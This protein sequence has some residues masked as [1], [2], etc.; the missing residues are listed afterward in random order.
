MQAALLQRT[1][2]TKLREIIVANQDKKHNIVVLGDLNVL[3]SAE[4]TSSVRPLPTAIEDFQDWQ[5]R[6]GLSNAL[7]HG[8]TGASIEK[9]YF[10]RSRTSRHGAELSLIDHIL[11]T[12]G[13]CRGAGV[14]VLPAG[15]VG[16]TDRMGDHDALLADL[17]CGFQPVPSQEKRPG[18]KWAHTFSPQAWEELNSDPTISNELDALL[19]ALEREGM[20]YDSQRL[21]Q[22]FERVLTVS[23]PEEVE[24]RDI[25]RAA[26]CI[27]RS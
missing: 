1:L 19:I 7:L 21:D 27:P 18:I 16:R 8:D 5:H 12:P 26:R 4:F 3:P 11:V 14:L 20:D 6:L 15:A 25:G 10:T 22:I 17:D 2:W 23:T 13:M 9:G 24:D